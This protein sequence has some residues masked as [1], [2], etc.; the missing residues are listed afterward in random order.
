MGLQNK[1]SHQIRRQNY[2]KVE[3]KTDFFHQN[4]IKLENKTL[5]PMFFELLMTNEV[6]LRST[7]IKP[8]IGV[9]E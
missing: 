1:I 8:T 3:K 9:Q 7:V 5:V 6:K 2:Y 4:V